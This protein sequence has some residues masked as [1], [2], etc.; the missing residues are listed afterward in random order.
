MGR[1]NPNDTT[2]ELKLDDMVLIASAEHSLWPIF[3]DEM[4]KESDLPIR[5]L[6][7]SP[8]FRREAW[9]YGKDMKW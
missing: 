6:W 4:L 8:A 2:Y 1:Y 3:A 5:Y 9:S 7:F